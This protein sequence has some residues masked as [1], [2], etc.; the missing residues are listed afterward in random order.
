MLSPCTHTSVRHTRAHADCMLSAATPAPAELALLGPWPDHL[1]GRG[2]KLREQ[3]LISVWQVQWGLHAVW[4]WGGGRP[5]SPLIKGRALCQLS[6]TAPGLRSLDQWRQVHRC[7][8][9]PPCSLSLWPPSQVRG[10]LLMPN[11]GTGACLSTLLMGTNRSHC[12][13]AGTG[14]ALSLPHPQS[15]TPP[16]PPATPLE[17]SLACAWWHLAHHELRH[18]GQQRT[19]PPA[20]ETALRVGASCQR[21]RRTPQSPAAPWLPATWRGIPGI[22]V[23]E[24]RPAALFSGGTALAGWCWHEELIQ[25]HRAAL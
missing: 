16:P 25:G 2:D 3:L 8:G 15:R 9:G 24:K 18:S 1:P 12:E 21:P 13:T 19:G 5:A 14:P 6:A 4:W 10:G 17:P 20:S 23:W 7:H 11:A 22:R